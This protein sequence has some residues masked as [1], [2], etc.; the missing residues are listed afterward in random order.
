MFNILCCILFHFINVQFSPGNIIEIYNS[1]IKS[2]NISL[3][4]PI[5]TYY[6]RLFYLMKTRFSTISIDS[7]LAIIEYPAEY[8]FSYIEYL[9]SQFSSL[10]EYIETSYSNIYSKFSTDNIGFGILPFKEINEKILLLEKAKEKKISLWEY[11]AQIDAL[12]ELYQNFVNQSQNYNKIEDCVKYLLKNIAPE[13]YSNFSD[14]TKRAYDIHNNFEINIDYNWNENVNGYSKKDIIYDK[15]SGLQMDFYFPN[16]FSN[17]KENG[18]F[19]FIH[20]GGF[21]EGDKEGEIRYISMIVS[22]GYA[23]ASIN[24]TLLNTNNDTSFEQI[25]ND[26]QASIDKIKYL[27]DEQNWNIKYLATSGGSAGGHLSLLYSYTRNNVSSIPI[28]FAVSYVPIVEF[29]KESMSRSILKDD[30]T[31]ILS[32]GLNMNITKENFDIDNEIINEVRKYSPL[33]QVNKKSV[34]S[35]ILSGMKDVIVDWKGGKKMVEKFKENNIEYDY[36]ELPNSGH[37][38]PIE[39]QDNQLI[40]DFDNLMGEWAKKYFG[41]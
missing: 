20:G 10:N 25:L 33:Y 29:S 28:K 12:D 34:P 39:H 21:T 9:P 18:M 3:K 8:N 14:I 31:N 16:N 38:Y 37:L 41:Y 35:L 1:N 17:E 22:K 30:I 27:S 36:I 2:F 4:Y 11:E 40:I 13:K 23:C 5:Y 7:L 32:M 19:L 24:Y 6:F 15:K 26:I